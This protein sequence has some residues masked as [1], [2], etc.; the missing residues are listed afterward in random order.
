M[1]YV[2]EVLV[3][4]SPTPERREQA[5]SWVKKALTLLLRAKSAAD[6]GEETRGEIDQLLASTLYNLGSFRE[7]SI[8]NVISLWLMHMCVTSFTLCFLF[9]DGQ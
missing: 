2:A 3:R 8:V 1:N 7:V 9:A 4:I 5:E 6:A